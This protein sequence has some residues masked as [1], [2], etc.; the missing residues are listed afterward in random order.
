[1]E[2]HCIDV[3]RIG[4]IVDLP[5]NDP[6]RR[7][8]ETCPRCRS[9]VE[10]YLAFAKAEP[11]TGSG[12]E[13]ACGVLDASIRKG[14]ERWIPTETRTSSLS[15]RAP[16]WHGL[17]RPAPLVAAA[18]IVVASVFLF[19]SRTPDPGVLR[20]D[21]MESEPFSLLPSEV[22]EDGSISLSW[23]AMTGADAYEVRIYGPD[24]SEVYR[25]PAAAETSTVIARSLLPADLPPSLDLTW[26]VYALSGGDVIE[27]SGPG[28]IRAP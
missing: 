17:L 26:R 13:H 20:D 14:A 12:V 15:A 11:V 24:L 28:S 16:W 22:G 9:L 8:A 19:T 2:A 6:E 3:E 4:E 1:M 5:A 21:A 18:S 25:H 27:I 23:T 7:H 10:S